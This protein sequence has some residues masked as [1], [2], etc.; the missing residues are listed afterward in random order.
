MGI[1]SYFS[2]I[3]KQH[4]AIIRP[5]LKGV[6]KINNLYLDCNSIIYD[7]VH[8]PEMKDTVTEKLD[9]KKLITAV[10]DKLVYYIQLIEPSKRVFIAFDGIA[11]IAKLNQQRNRRYMSLLQQQLSPEQRLLE[12]Q[13]I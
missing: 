3:V 9:E 7:A 5:Y 8:K 12:G 13:P 6:E 4:R 10:C 2:H 11:P 1:P